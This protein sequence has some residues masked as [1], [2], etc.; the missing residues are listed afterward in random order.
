M[1]FQSAVAIA[2][3][4]RRRAE[5]QYCTTKY[6]SNRCV[7][8]SWALAEK[9]R[10]KGLDAF[11]IWGFVTIRGKQRGHSWVECK[12]V[13]F[14]LTRTQFQRAADPVSVF[15]VDHPD[16]EKRFPVFSIEHMRRCDASEQMIQDA[17]RL[18]A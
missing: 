6:L 4:V 10:S 8:V 13:I 16:Y 1:T 2:E 18:A 12:G 5:R 3:E 11:M 15:E 9:F 14:D 7:P 17:R